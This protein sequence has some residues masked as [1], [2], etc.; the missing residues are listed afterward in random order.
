[1]YIYTSNLHDGA[2]FSI[3]CNA[4][5]IISYIDVHLHRTKKCVYI[6]VTRVESMDE[7]QGK[8]YLACL[9]RPKQE[10]LGQSHYNHSIEWQGGVLA[11]ECGDL[12]SLFFRRKRESKSQ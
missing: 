8:E 9:C 12:I 5:C 10:K 11:Q 7:H 2:S 1:M 3:R 6:L 4:S